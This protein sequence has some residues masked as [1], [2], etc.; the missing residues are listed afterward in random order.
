MNYCSLFIYMIFIDLIQNE[1]MIFLNHQSE[2]SSFHEEIEFT[3]TVHL[4][5]WEKGKL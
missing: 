3:V 1:N 5:K 2:S 4:E